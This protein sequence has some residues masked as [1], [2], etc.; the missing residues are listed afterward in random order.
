MKETQAAGKT[1]LRIQS[2]RE[3]RDHQGWFL[4]TETII[5]FTS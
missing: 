2:H 5:D 4:E 1:A 3:R